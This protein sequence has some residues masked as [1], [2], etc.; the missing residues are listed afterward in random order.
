MYSAMVY[1]ERKYIKMG[2]QGI[3]KMTKIDIGETKRN[4]RKQAQH[5]KIMNAIR[6]IEYPNGEW[7]NQKGRPKGSK[8]KENPKA[9]LIQEYVA[10]HPDANVTE[11]AR[12][13]GI[14]RPTVYKW[15]NNKERQDVQETIWELTCERWN[16]KDIYEYISEGGN[17][18]IERV[19]QYASELWDELNRQVSDD[20]YN[21]LYP[22]R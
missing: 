9:K 11:I 17:I 19:K 15:L 4:G 20:L 12:D 14:S 22:P 3:R 1:Y 8:N 13:L 7:R 6:E 21:T 10:M 16:T 2:R 5:V 18:P